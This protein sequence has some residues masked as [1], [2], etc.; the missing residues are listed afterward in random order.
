MATSTTAPQPPANLLPAY[1]LLNRLAIRADEP[2]AAL[3][4]RVLDALAT[5]QS[6]MIP[7]LRH[8][9]AADLGE[10]LADQWQMLI[11]TPA[12]NRDDL[13][14]A[15]LIQFV[16]RLARDAATE[17]ANQSGAKP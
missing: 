13:V 17:A 12:P 2:T 15:D 14:W 10:R 1:A 6:E 3:T 7:T 9:D 4:A 11:G 16:L 5:T 8:D